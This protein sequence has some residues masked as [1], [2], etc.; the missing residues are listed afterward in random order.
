MLP[1]NQRIHLPAEFR[2]LTRHGARKGTRTIVLHAAPAPA[3][4]S[5]RAGFVV[6]KTVGNAVVRNRVKRRLREILAEEL[7]QLAPYSLIVR[8][9]PQAARASFQEL[10]EDVH[11]VLRRIGAVKA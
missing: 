8:A 2:E 4:E 10:R 1:R 9:K 5:A 3:G 7:P 11:S 6:S